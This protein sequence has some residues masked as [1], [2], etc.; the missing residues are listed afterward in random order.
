ML[1]DI[2]VPSDAT[3]GKFNILC[4]TR[5]DLVVQL[6][7]PV[8]PASTANTQAAIDT[9]INLALSTFGNATNGV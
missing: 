2:Q 3:Y 5:N 6:P 9:A 8:A 7:T 1:F 4:G